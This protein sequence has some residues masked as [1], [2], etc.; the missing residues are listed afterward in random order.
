MM[1][2]KQLPQAPVLSALLVV[3]GLDAI[4]LSLSSCL[5]GFHLI[6]SYDT[7]LGFYY[8]I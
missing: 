8:F 3:K 6:I 4:P 7:L 2:M 5:F 1:K